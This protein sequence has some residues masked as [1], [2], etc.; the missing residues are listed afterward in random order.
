MRAHPCILHYQGCEGLIS[1]VLVGLLSVSR[2]R[3]VPKE[4]IE[5]IGCKSKA[6]CNFCSYICFSTA[7]SAKHMNPLVAHVCSF[8][9]LCPAFE[10]FFHNLSH[11]RPD[12]GQKSGVRVV[13]DGFA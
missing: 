5:I 11:A 1:L 12:G 3:S 7:W 9:A 8:A 13:T 6:C 2:Y 10:R 4:I